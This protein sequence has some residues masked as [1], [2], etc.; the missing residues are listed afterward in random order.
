MDL[1]LNEYA[2]LIKQAALGG[3]LPWGIAEEAGFAAKWLAARGVPFAEGFADLLASASESVG[4]GPG[5]PLTLGPMLSDAP[6]TIATGLSHEV[7]R[8][9]ILAP[10]CAAVASASRRAVVVDWAGGGFATDGLDLW[11]RDAGIASAMVTIRHDRSPDFAAL[12]CASRADIRPDDHAALQRHAARM[13]APATE[14]SRRLG[15]GSSL[16]DN[17]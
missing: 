11:T 7:Q 17:D 9:L 10:F 3:G 6:D 13:L 2:S 5:S 16:S 14:E 4:G 12:S 15:A 8:P 1:S